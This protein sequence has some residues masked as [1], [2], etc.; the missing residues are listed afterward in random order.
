MSRGRSAPRSGAP[1]SSSPNSSSSQAAPASLIPP[2][3]EIS[4]EDL[5]PLDPPHDQS[6]EVLAGFNQ[7]YRVPE[8]TIGPYVNCREMGFRITRHR[9]PQMTV[10]FAENR[11]SDDIVVYVAA[12]AHQ[13]ASPFAKHFDTAVEDEI[14]RNRR[15][16]RYDAHDHAQQ[17]I[18]ETLGAQT[19]TSLRRAAQRAQLLGSSPRFLDI[20]NRR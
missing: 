15:Y 6:F 9:D 8:A 7:H 12:G 18:A 17:F 11:N 4:P 5:D 2:P 19:L 3:L 1:A 14:Y 10:W 16:F 13:L 20:M